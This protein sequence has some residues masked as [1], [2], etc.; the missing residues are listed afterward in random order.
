[1]LRVIRVLLDSVA[2][3]MGLM[4]PTQQK[5]LPPIDDRILLESASSLSQR[6]KSGKVLSRF[7]VYLCV[8][9]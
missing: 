4:W 9:V 3:L 6:I 5:Y 1:M 2:N 8:R 7:C